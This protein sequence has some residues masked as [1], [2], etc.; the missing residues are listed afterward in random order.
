M[1]TYIIFFL[2]SALLAVS[3]TPMVIRLARRVRAVDRP[4]VRT[5]HQ[6]P[7]PRIGGVAI[8][9]SAMCPLI[10]VALLNGAVDRAFEQMQR[11]ITILLCAATFVFLIGLVDDLKSLPARFKLLAELVAC[12]ALCLAGVRI[13]NIALTNHWVLS[14]GN[15][16]WVFTML[17]VVG[18]TNA[19]NLSDGLDGLA[20]GIS[21]V[22]CGTIAVFAI[23]SGDVAMGVFMLALV[24]SLSGFLVFN[25]NPA[26]VFMG[27]C[28]SLFL[29]FTIGSASVLCVAKSAALVGLALPA[30]ALGIPIFDTLFSMLRRFLERR[31]LFAPD[32]RHIH[33]RLL[34]LGL[35]Q[36]HAVVMIHLV[37]LLTTG[38]GLFMMVNQNLSSLV[39]F[40]C[41]LLLIMLLF[42]VVGAV[43]LGETMTQLRERYAISQ[44]QRQDRA[45]FEHSQLRFRQATDAAGWWQTVCETAQ[46]MGFAR[47]ALK[48]TYPDGRREEKLWHSPQS[49]PA[50]P[51]LVIMTLPFGNGD[52]TVSH[53]FEIAICVRGSLEAT[54]RRA[55]LFSRLVDEYA[56]TSVT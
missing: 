28:G 27:D 42:R 51:G 12:A 7:V 48:T 35:D 23:H 10:A 50:E 54:A 1:T 45:V 47:V 31:S 19:V 39:V 26:R 13:S 37:T 43:R 52:P 22:A 2:S 16:G 8:F 11:E 53:Q 46:R 15:W 55:S 49:P 18:I 40:G 5:V 41:V 33:H 3:I 29:G 6:E 34:D 38:L 25:F 30:L 32:R 14:L 17:W 21:A 44:Q 56:A 4:G 36:R 9:L 24:G 20:A